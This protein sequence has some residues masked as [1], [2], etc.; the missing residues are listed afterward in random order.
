MRMS[1]AGYKVLKDFERCV[2]IAYPDP[3]TGGDPWTCGWGAT[4]PDVRRGTVWTQQHADDRLAADVAYR[5]RTVTLA[6]GGT[7]CT[8]GQFDALVDIVYNVGVGSQTKDGIVRLKS[9][10]QSTLLRKF[11]ACD[12][13]GC[14]AEFL[15]WVSPGTNVEA[16]LRRR[17]EAELVLFNGT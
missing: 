13:V 7:P 16:G 8:Q 3:K 11:L 6:I 1:P 17:R 12:Y 2:L 5:E 10:A 9:G 4:G 14:A 15:K